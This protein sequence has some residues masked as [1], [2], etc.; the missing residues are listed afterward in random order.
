MGLPTTLWWNSESRRDLPIPA[1][2][3]IPTICPWPRIADSRRLHRSSISRWRPTNVATC[4]P[5]RLDARPARTK[6][7]PRTPP[8][9]S[10]SSNR[11]SRNG[12][13]ASVTRIDPGSPCSTSAPSTSTAFCLAST[14]SSVARGAS[15]TRQCVRWIPTVTAGT[16]GSS[17]RARLLDRQGG[18]RRG[19][20]RA[21]GR[22]GPERGDDAR[23][24]HPLDAP[25]EARDLL[26]QDLESA[27]R[28]ARL[29]RLGGEGERRPQERHAPPLPVERG[30]R[31]RGDRW[32]A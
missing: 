30:P 2:P 25:A 1:S 10:S 13:A 20:G 22:V 5:R 14:A 8:A 27:A 15:P 6:T 4:R 16:R 24:A 7:R 28:L 29:V 19:A 32:L 9:K 26:E 3:L 18:V 11:R 21:L 23:R 31:R 12:A 17:W